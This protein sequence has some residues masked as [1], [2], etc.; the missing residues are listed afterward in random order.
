METAQPHPP[1]HS[2]LSTVQGEI[3]LTSYKLEPLLTGKDPSSPE[4]SCHITVQ[5][6]KEHQGGPKYN[7]IVSN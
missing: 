3:C 4:E 7:T 2:W 5:G 1:S 6:A